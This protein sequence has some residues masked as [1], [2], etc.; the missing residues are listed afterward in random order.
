MEVILLERIEKLG[1][2]GD[3]VRV[4]DGFARNFL[5]PQRKAL[6]ATKANLGEFQSRRVQFEAHNLE[7][8]AEAEQI[9]GRLDGLSCVVLRQASEGGQLYGS[10]TARD[11]AEAAV[12]AGFTVGRGQVVLDGPIKSLGLHRVRVRLHPEVSVAVTINV[13][14]SAAE[15]EVQARGGPGAPVDLAPEAAAAFFENPEE[16]VAAERARARGPTTAA[17]EE[18]AKA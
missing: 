11:I 16:V 17:G 5:L 3:V 13:A 1:Q 7:R 4:K 10:V 14:R 2:M 18:N 12:A 8:R 6:R 15:A 9:A